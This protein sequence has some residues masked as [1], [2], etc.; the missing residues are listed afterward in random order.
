MSDKDVALVKIDGRGTLT[1]AKWGDVKKVFLGD[2]VLCA[3]STLGLSHSFS[4]G[5]VRYC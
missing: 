3:G 4:K 1:P 5:V 2:L